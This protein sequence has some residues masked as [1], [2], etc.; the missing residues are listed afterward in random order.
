[1]TT[2]AWSLID[3]DKPHL[4]LFKKFDWYGLV[5]MAAFLGALEYVLEEGP[6]HDWLQDQAVFVCAVVSTVGAVLFFFRAFTAEEPIVDLKAFTNINFAFGSIFSFVMGIGLYGLTYLYPIFLGRI[7]GY[8]SMMIGEALFV[9]GLAMFFTAPVSGFLSRKMD[10]RLM[11]MVG[12]LGFAAGTWRMTNLTADWDF[13]ELLVPQ[14]LRGCSLMLCMVPINN[15]ALGTL[16]PERLKN[17]SGLF[18]LTRNLGGAVGLALINTALT[19]RNTF[20]YE[21][22]AEHVQWGSEAAQDKLQQMT[23]NFE[24]HS[25]MDAQTAAISKLSGMAHQQAALLSFIDVFYLLTVLFA[26]LALFVMFIRKP[27]AS[28]SGGG[29]H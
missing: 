11:M 22:M 5:G 20:H 25:G 21:R 16:P 13:G 28:A 18:N 6:N 14:I 12:F 15:I 8:D 23:L 26:S 7:R 2:A 29:G 4:A 24:T 10:P 17:A 19:Q 3:F 9:S 1:V 27:P